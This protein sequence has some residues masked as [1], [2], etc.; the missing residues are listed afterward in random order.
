M[1]DLKAALGEALGPLCRVEREVRPAG[2]YR[3]F[4]V[5]PIPSGPALLVKVLP[6]AESLTIDENE[7]E[8]GV[9]LLADRL[10]H[11][12]LVPPKGGGRA[13]AFIF[14]TRPFVEGT[15]LQAWMVRNGQLPLARAVE[16][17]R[18][19]L[20]GLAHAHSQK[21]AHGGLR[22][23]CVILGTEG[24]LLADTGIRKLLG[25]AT[26]LRNDMAAL[27]LLVHEMLTG[28]AH[29]AMEEPV[30]A[31]RSLPQWLSDWVQ[32]QWSDARTAL[33][34]LRPPPP[35]SHSSRMRQP[36]V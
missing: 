24:P 22:T 2:P 26:L 5:T 27:A 1:S 10:R 20:N 34:A 9:L 17:L 7:F 21:V 23:D 4:V 16:T 13:G 8:R 30:E 32:T 11:A 25:G 6:A 18:G 15:T 28:T 31:N 3:Q 33:A 14:H 12:N 35:Q 36:F 29:R 19:I